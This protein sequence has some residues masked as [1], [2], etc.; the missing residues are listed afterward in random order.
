MGPVHI[1]PGVSELDT[2]AQ[3]ALMAFRNEI[4]ILNYS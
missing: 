2:M 3:Y 4:E 1:Y